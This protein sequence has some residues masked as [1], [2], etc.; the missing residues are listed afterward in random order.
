[1]NLSKRLQSIADLISMGSVAVD[2]GT[3]HAFLPVYLIEKTISKKVIAT[4]VNKKPLQKAKKCISE[5]RFNDKIELRFG[6]GLEVIKPDEVD[7]II[8]AGMGGS[9][10]QSILS[11]G[12]DVARTAKELIIQPMTMHVETREWLDKNDY[13]I[14]DENLVEED[15]R[16]Y[17]IMKITPNKTC[18][19][20]QYEKYFGRIL[21]EK[22]HPLLKKY[23]L[24]G[25][26]DLRDIV[27][28]MSGNNNGDNRERLDEVK[29][30]LAVYNRYL[31]KMIEN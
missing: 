2:I 22:K 17:L 7:C 6:N 27:D 9:T 8:I 3:D 15:R 1:M 28:E 11:D 26:K 21:F 25:I 19:L 18:G 4:D 29:A 14:I 20:G 10:I 30:K 12:K 5:N 31:E 13:M 24:K 16:L 23:V